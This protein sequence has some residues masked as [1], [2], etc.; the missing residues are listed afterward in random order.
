MWMTGDGSRLYRE[1]VVLQVVFSLTVGLTKLLRGH[2]GF[3]R[4]PAASVLAGHPAEIVGRTRKLS[5]IIVLE[6]VY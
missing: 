6:L 3:R 4:E 1:Q 5:A 2:E